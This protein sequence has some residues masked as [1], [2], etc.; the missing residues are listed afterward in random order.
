MVT[1]SQHLATPL[2]VGAAVLPGTLRARLEEARA[3]GDRFNIKQAVGIIV[4][5]CVEV[6][7]LHRAGHRLFVHPSALI[8]NGGSVWDY[9]GKDLVPRPGPPVLC[10][11][12]TCVRWGRPWL[13]AA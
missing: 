6:A 3:R 7:D 9:R 4:P 8:E 1:T 10:M 13:A 11:P 12:T 5:L 2:P